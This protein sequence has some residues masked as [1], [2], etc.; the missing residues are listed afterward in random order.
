MF[1]FTKITGHNTGKIMCLNKV[2]IKNY[3]FKDSGEHWFF[4][5]NNHNKSKRQEETFGG[6]RYVYGIEWWLAR[7]GKGKIRVIFQWI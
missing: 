1:Y 4:L 5:S 6:D 3:S 7:D 2:R